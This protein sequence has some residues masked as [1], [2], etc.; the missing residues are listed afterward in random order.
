MH[1]TEIST[2]TNKDGFSPTVFRS[3]LEHKIPVTEFLAVAY[4]FS[5]CEARSL[6]HVSL[7]SE[8]TKAEAIV[9]IVEPVKPNG[10]R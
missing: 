6:S 4:V 9:A 5:Q 1:Q 3:R 10:K 2:K 8:I 7:S